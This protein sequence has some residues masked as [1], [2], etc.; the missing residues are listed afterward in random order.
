RMQRRTLP[1]LSSDAPCSSLPAPFWGG[2]PIGRRSL[3]SIRETLEVHYRKCRSRVFRLHE[4]IEAA[5]VKRGRAYLDIGGA[6][7]SVFDARRGLLRYRR[8]QDNS[9]SARKDIRSAR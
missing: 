7:R 1:L 2:L 5:D 8:S 3:P 6:P 9:V 4:K